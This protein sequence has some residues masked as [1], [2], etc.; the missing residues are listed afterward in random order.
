MRF[1]LAIYAMRIKTLQYISVDHF[2]F[3]RFQMI[4]YLEPEKKHLLNTRFI[5]DKISWE[6]KQAGVQVFFFLKTIWNDWQLYKTRLCCCWNL[7]N[8]HFQSSSVS[9]RMRLYTVVIFITYIRGTYKIASIIQ[10]VA[11]II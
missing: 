11:S 3:L 4:N 10:Q 5:C 1:Y 8:V 6:M 7:T 2:I 9:L